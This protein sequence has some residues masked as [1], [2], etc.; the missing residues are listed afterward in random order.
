MRNA[1]ERVFQGE[2]SFKPERFQTR[3]NPCE[4]S[5]RFAGPGWFDPGGKS[6]SWFRF[7]QS[8]SPIDGQSRYPEGVSMPV[9]SPL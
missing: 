8:D 1:L 2:H 4:L 5:A 3:L 7:F 6:L 9:F